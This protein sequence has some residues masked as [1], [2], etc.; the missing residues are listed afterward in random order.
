MKNCEQFRELIEAF[1]LGALDADERVALDVHLAS[2]CTDCAQSVEEA[3]LAV[4]HLAYLAPEEMPSSALKDRLMRAVRA[5]VQ[6]S[7]PSASRKPAIWAWMGVAALVALT[8]YSAWDAWRL[9]TKFREANDQTAKAIQNGQSLWE[10]LDLAQREVTILTDPASV[11]IALLPQNPQAPPLE[12]KWHSQL[13]MVVTG[14]QV[15]V[16]P[17][18]RVLQLWL[19]P[20]APGTKPVPSLTLR[21]GPGGK[22]VL[23]VFDPPKLLAETKALA[24]TEEPAGGSPQPTTAILWVGGVS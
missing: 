20:K 9:R 22:F 13:G 7:R 16:P 19:I 1:A 4:S 6:A 8:V 10:Q 17:G 5:E 3:R 12:L 23:P 14:Q 11:K 2:G 15:P 18:N 24:I 21:P